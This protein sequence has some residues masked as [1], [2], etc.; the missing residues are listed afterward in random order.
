MI[1]QVALETHQLTVNYD[2][3]LVL[4]DVSLSVPPGKIVA[5]IGP[6][7]AGKTTFIKTVLGIV[8]PISGRVEFFGKPFN[9]ARRR[10]AYVPQREAVDWN[11]PV[12]VLELVMMG[13]YGHSGMF[14]WFR[15]A[16]REAARRYLAM[17][18]M[19][20]YAE[21]QI[22]Q[23]SGGQQQRV[24]LARALLQ[25]AD[26]YFMDE[27]FVGIDMI[28]EKVLVELLHKL[29]AKG[30]TIFVVHHDLNT[31]ETYF[32]WVVI[33]NMRLIACGSIK[34][35]YTPE[36]IERAYGKGGVLLGEA[37][38]MAEECTSGLLP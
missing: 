23:L 32:D 25:E 17:V 13:R 14:K 30:K 38:R 8:K 33:L 37:A 15:K 20:E 26:I 35:A 3:A 24:F 18:G 10:I 34:E 29:R 7:G 4:W 2:K 1:S 28:T 5:V 19:A 12:T 6:N 31:I 16:D 9:N 21:R 11:F 36:N 22:S 27:P